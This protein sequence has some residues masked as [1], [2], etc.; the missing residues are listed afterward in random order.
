MSS[1]K[2]AAMG[3]N[4]LGSSPY[5]NLISPP[6]MP[7]PSGVE[8]R[9]KTEKKVPAKKE[10]KVRL[11][12]LLDESL[13]NEVR[14]AVVELQGPPVFLSVSKFVEIAVKAELEKLRKDHNEGKP[15]EAAGS[16]PKRGRPVVM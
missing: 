4:P 10:V 7:K 15:F 16:A 3:S 6:V 9:A 14:Y 11:S 2:V 5:D 8:P 13:V 12:A 1:K